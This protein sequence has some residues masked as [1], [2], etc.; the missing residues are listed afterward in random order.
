MARIKWWWE[1]RRR[2]SQRRLRRMELPSRPPDGLGERA[3]LPWRASG[4]KLGPEGA[5]NRRQSDRSSPA[6]CVLQSGT[7]RP[8]QDRTTLGS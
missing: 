8:F 5:S 3:R 6:A 4:R 2:W 7:I 1:R